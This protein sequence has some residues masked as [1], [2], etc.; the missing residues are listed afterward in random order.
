MR[1]VTP[2]PTTTA[3][4]GTIRAAPPPAP[5]VYVANAPPPS[6]SPPFYG[7]AVP[8]SSPA[9]AAWDT[10]SYTTYPATTSYIKVATADPSPSL[11]A[12]RPAVATGTP[13]PELEP[14]PVV[15]ISDLVSKFKE[16]GHALISAR[17][18]WQELFHP[19]SFSRPANIGDAINR[20]RRNATYFPCKLHPDNPW[21]SS[22]RTAPL[23]ILGRTIDD[24]SVLMWLTVATVVS[25]MFTSV[26]W[27]VIGSTAVG[28][29][30]VG[31]HA[32]F[33][34]T[35]DLFLSEQEAA[36]GG[37]INPTMAQFAQVL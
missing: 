15:R 3:S 31:V 27:N 17:R 26:G 13:A 21:C 20:I 5:A 11:A 19:P 36:G 24:G 9:V 32:A 34:S 30:V 35:D 18:P 23:V 16:Q 7:A 22:D 25:L 6:S 14:S 4:Y 1:N 10:Y 12:V 33:R 28:V 2:N 29:A 37:L 8:P